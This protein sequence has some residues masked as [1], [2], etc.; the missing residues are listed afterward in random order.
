MSPKPDHDSDNEEEIEDLT[1]DMMKEGNDDLIENAGQVHLAASQAWGRGVVA[2]IRRTIG[3]HWFKEMTNFNQKTVAV[4]CLIFISIIPPTLAFGAS[5]GKM[6]NNRVGAIETIL[7]T[8]WVGVAYSLIG[9]MPM[10]IIGSTGPALALST[11]I[12]N[13]SESAGMEYLSFNGWISIWLL[14]Y[15]VAAGFF[16]LT[17]YVKLAT[18]FTD[19]IFALLIVAI[20]VMDAVGDPFSPSGILRYFDD[21]HRSHAIH[22]GDEDYE[23]LTVALLSTILGFGTTALIFFFR[24][25]KFS[26]FFCSDNSRSLVHDFAVTM[27]VLIW[28]LVKEFLFP[29]VNTEGLQVPDKFEPS[30]QCCDAECT[31][32]WPTECEGQEAPVGTRNWFVDLF[33]VPSWAPFAAAGPA[34]MAFLLCYLDNGITWHL[35]NHKHHKLTHGEAYNYDLCLS[36][37][38]NCINGLMGLPW[39]VATTVPCIIHLNSLAD[40]D[41]QG[42]F[43]YVQETRLTMFFSHALLGLCMLFLG[44]LKLLPLPVLYGVFLF[45]GL[46]SLPGI[47]FWNRFLLFFQQPS[48]WPET[49]FTKYME[50][51]RI[52]KYTIIQML[53]FCGVFGVMNVKAISIAFP[54]MTFLC[55]P[56]RL[57]FL[58]KFFKGWELCVL[59]GEDDQ[60]EEWTQAKH[61]SIRGFSFRAND[62]PAVLGEDDEDIPEV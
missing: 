19:E 61:D 30:F 1:L 14:F 40:K 11:A 18:R 47:Q 53:F 39:L 50:K 4:A 62:D 12:K 23:Y 55:I 33:S 21:E 42:N 16:D 31:K 22:E 37:F 10:C 52:H 5:Y 3:T 38:F 7:A 51:G 56:A 28:T 15:C 27:S 46:S 17:R 41:A 43:L 49:V 8:S 54:F 34:I 48:R 44:V 20:F 58:P 60:I 9:G 59:D 24:S 45:M 29:N 32:F 26:S 13:I 2:D 35:I 57:F 25:F 36:G 6:S